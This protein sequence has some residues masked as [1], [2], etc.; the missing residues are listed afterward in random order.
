MI[1]M[2]MKKVKKKDIIT[3]SRLSGRRNSMLVRNTNFSRP[4]EECRVSACH[5]LWLRTKARSTFLL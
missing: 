4:F 1:I 2:L 3:Q 5:Q